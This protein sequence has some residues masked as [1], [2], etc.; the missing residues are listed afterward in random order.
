ME[1]FLKEIMKLSKFL[2][3]SDCEFQDIV[4]KHRNKEIWRKMNDN[5]WN[6]IHPPK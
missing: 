2:N 1:N 4:D 6:L 3:L 5:S